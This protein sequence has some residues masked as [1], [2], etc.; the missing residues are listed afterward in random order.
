VSNVD[1]ESVAKATLHPLQVRIIEHATAS[2]ERF[3]PSELAAE[4]GVPL[5]NCSY[6]VRVLS[7]LKLIEPAGTKTVRGALKHYY[8]GSRGLVG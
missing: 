8:R 3:S 4:W 7:G 6:H 5:G 2:D 1:W